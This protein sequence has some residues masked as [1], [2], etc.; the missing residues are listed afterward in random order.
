M[1]RYRLLKRVLNAAQLAATQLAVQAHR[2][3]VAVAGAGTA[4]RTD[5]RPAACT[6][7]KI[8][9]E[10]AVAGAL[11]IVGAVDVLAKMFPA[12]CSALLGRCGG[13]AEDLLTG[14]ATGGGFVTKVTLASPLDARTVRHPVLTLSCE[15]TAVIEW[16]ACWDGAAIL[17]NQI[18]KNNKVY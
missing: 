14:G 9:V 4:Q 10:V 1:Q 15:E 18:V 11:I 2:G 13:V 7:H 16:I 6:R 3:A 12:H 8:V 17:I 5:H